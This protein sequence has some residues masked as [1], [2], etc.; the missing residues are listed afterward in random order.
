MTV[1]IHPYKGYL[2]TVFHI[3]ATGIAPVKYRVM[4]RTEAEDVEV[5]DGNVK[6]N[7]PHTLQVP[8]PG[9]FSI[10]CPDGTSIPFTVE[11][12]YKY[13]GGRF[14]QAFV[15]DN[16]SWLFVVM[17]DRTY[18]Y[19]RENKV[20]YV[21][22][23]SPDEISEISSDYVIFSNKGQEERTIY[24]LTE[25]KPILCIKNIVLTNS[26]VVIWQEQEKE[27]DE[28]TI[29]IYSLKSK[30]EI[31]RFDI[32]NFMKDEGNERLIYSNDNQ[33]YSV[34]LHDNLEIEPVLNTGKETIVALVAPNLVVCYRSVSYGKFVTI[35]DINKKKCIKNLE[36]NG[37]LSK[38]GDTEIID[39]WNRQQKIKNFN[40]IEAE[41]PE[42]I[43][44]ADFIELEFYPCEWDVFYTKKHIHLEN[45]KPYPN[46]DSK[47]EIHLHSFNSDLNQLLK[48]TFEHFLSIHDTVCLYNFKESFVRNKSYGAAGYLEGGRIYESRGRV[49]RYVEKKLYTLSRNGYWDNERGVDLSFDYF[50]NFRLL[51]NKETKQ[52]LTVN[53]INLSK[54]K[55]VAYPNDPLKRVLRTSEYFVLP[56]ARFL[57]RN[58][59]TLPSC[60]SENLKFGL[61]V[62]DDKV[63]LYSFSGED[64]ISE[65]ILSDIFDYS[66]FRDVLLS[67]DGKSIMHRDNEESIIM[68]IAT[69][70]S[71]SYE[72]V[73]FVKQVNGIRPLFDSPSS[74]QPRLINPVTGQPIDCNAMSQFQFISPD[75]SLYAD[76]RLK[77]YIEYYWHEDN[78][79]LSHKEYNRLMT[80]YQYPWQEK[81]DSEA[82]RKVKELRR[83][84]VLEHFDFLNERFP[85]LLHG[86]KTGKKWE[87][88]VL[89]E[90]NTFGTKGFLNRL[91]GTKGIAYIRR[92]SN[93]TEVAKIELGEPLSYINYVSFS[94][95]SRYVALAGYRRDGYSAWGGLFLIYDLKKGKTI[96][97]QNTNRAVWLTSFSK[98]NALASYTSDPFTFLATNESEYDNDF[99]SM[100]IERRNFL[101]FSPDGIYFA[102]SEQGY[103]SKYDKYGNV[104]PGWGHQPS[105]LVEVRLTNQ[106]SIEGLRF[107]D[108]SDQGIAD[109]A[110]KAASVASVSFSNDNKRLM[111][112]GNDGVVIIRNLHLNDNAGQ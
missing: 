106:A 41:I 19:N 15:F 34:A 62:K 27:N 97:F 65:E 28:I 89:D 40:K 22:S 90:Q 49:V 1:S 86:D 48:D 35:Y 55:S 68:D 102:L 7:E 84:L 46:L 95:D 33:V 8:I 72:N 80:K 109:V 74:L 17:H 51:E 105:S 43:I 58:I 112:V 54:F 103:V 110:T 81:K 21:E 23:I 107:S 98:E 44:S 31:H 77:E 4:R 96:V 64:I 100:L 69:G 52:I 83:Q 61:D 63:L 53:G 101:T 25:Q 70:K 26:E 16:C 45:S 59:G 38:V 71:E 37:H 5:M 32:D 9:E 10:E 24:S 111:M 57:K 87:T 104:N 30:N 13:G 11:D 14:K 66:K 75:G 82:W 78:T 85:K 93:D 67:E 20:A 60:M 99:K 73:S 92:S 50:D 6:P 36:I 56:G 94:Y 18:F 2:N 47:E 79:T 91:I 108:I 76:T 88:I 12:G 29:V 39:V 3:H 42:A